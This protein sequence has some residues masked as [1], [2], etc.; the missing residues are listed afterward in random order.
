M[1]IS[2]HPAGDIQ[3]M[4]L[5]GLVIKGLEQEHSWFD[6]CDC[7]GE[8]PRNVSCSTISGLS[9][10]P[11]TAS[12]CSVESI[13]TWQDEMEHVFSIREDDDAEDTGGRERTLSNWWAEDGPVRSIDERDEITVKEYCAAT[14]STATR[15]IRWEKEEC[16][17]LMGSLTT[18]RSICWEDECETAAAFTAAA[19]PTSNDLQA[20]AA[21]DFVPEGDS[22][23][24]EFAL[25][26]RCEDQTDAFWLQFPSS[27]A[28]TVGVEED[29]V[30]ETAAQGADVTLPQDAIAKAVSAAADVEDSPGWGDVLSA[31]L[32]GLVCSRP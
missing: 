20:A 8:L 26:A 23:V 4:G 19:R 17:A 30:E 22:A 28:S 3:V 6:A 31:M 12:T 24:G 14:G 27:G 1:S 11:R 21:E 18:I 2:V 32:S 7:K 25:P 9:G 5:P 15:S 16:D 10:F 29:L 13:C